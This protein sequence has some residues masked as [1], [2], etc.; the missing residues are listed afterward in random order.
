[1]SVHMV[2]VHVHIYRL[3]AIYH[4]KVTGLRTGTF[5]LSQNMLLIV[6]DRL[7]SSQSFSSGLRTTKQQCPYMG[8]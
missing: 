4:N 3:S 2:Q 6:K 8:C 1:M 5:S 7:S